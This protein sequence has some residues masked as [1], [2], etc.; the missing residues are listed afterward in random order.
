MNIIKI[1]NESVRPNDK[2]FK[3]RL[4]V[5]NNCITSLLRFELP[6]DDNEK[7][8]FRFYYLLWFILWA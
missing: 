4:F 7:K 5:S 1:K 2:T 6:R 8:R 3:N